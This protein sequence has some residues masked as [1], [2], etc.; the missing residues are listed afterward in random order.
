MEVT[1]PCDPYSP[2]V[3]SVLGGFRM[4]RVVV[5]TDND[6]R[7]FIWRMLMLSLQKA[8]GSA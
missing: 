3:W 8:V 7:V 1:L 2:P 5:R 4:R 6:L